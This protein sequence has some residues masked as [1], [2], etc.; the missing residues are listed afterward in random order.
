MTRRLHSLNKV[1]RR[2]GELVTD[3]TEASVQLH[4]DS[5][6]LMQAVSRFRLPA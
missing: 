2:T 1:A 3:A 5:H 4:N 6:A